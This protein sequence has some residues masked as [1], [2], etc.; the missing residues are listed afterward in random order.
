MKCIFTVVAGSQFSPKPRLDS[1]FIYQQTLRSNTK[2]S[3]AEEPNVCLFYLKSLTKKNNNKKKEEGWRKPAGTNA[4]PEALQVFRRARARSASAAGRVLPP[5]RGQS[6]RTGT[7]TVTPAAALRHGARRP[8]PRPG[9]GARGQEGCPP[10]GNPHTLAVL[11][12]YQ[13]V[14]DGVR[15]RHQLLGLEQL[16]YV[17]AAG[18]LPL[19]QPQ[20]CHRPARPPSWSRSPAEALATARP[21]DIDFPY[22]APRSPPAEQRP[23]GHRN[24]AETAAST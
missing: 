11:R 17:A 8:F 18:L 14:R 20:R 22:G 19:A 16:Q 2:W 21:S 10:Q 23:L 13:T 6:E 4:A 12:M 3:I 15:Q 7:R 9:M 24:R 5:A 1:Q